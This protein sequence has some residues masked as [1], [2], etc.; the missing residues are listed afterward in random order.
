MK[1]AAGLVKV[2][3]EAFGIVLLSAVIGLA[4][5][6]L[7][8]GGIPLLPPPPNPVSDTLRVGIEE[9]KK[10]FDE[11][12]TLF[13]DARSETAYHEGHIEGALHLPMEALQIDATLDDL[14][15]RFPEIAAKII[16]SPEI[17]TYCSGEDCH[18]SV[19]LAT[20]LMEIGCENVK[21]FFG[22]WEAWSRAGYPVVA[23]GNPEV[24]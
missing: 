2:T 17:I 12:G 15:E 7:S 16:S 1:E 23:A 6:A 20:R 4:Y 8:D 19:E 3:L 18:S 24:F 11:Q 5:N 21:I 22:G 14:F 13:L 9:A 10:R